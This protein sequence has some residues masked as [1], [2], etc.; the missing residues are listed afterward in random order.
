MNKRVKWHWFFM[1]VCPTGIE[2]SFD[3]KLE[4]KSRKPWTS[5]DE[6]FTFLATAVSY[7]NQDHWKISQK[8][9]EA[10]KI[11]SVNWKEKIHL[12]CN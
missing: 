2:W 3:L 5:H 10:E 12:L 9:F 4:K 11:E 6:T 7:Y 8:I 1:P